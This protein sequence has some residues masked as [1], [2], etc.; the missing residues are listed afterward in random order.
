MCVFVCV[1]CEGRKRKRKRESERNGGGG[2]TAY[3]NLTWTCSPCRLPFS[4]HLLLLINTTGEEEERRQ[5]DGRNFSSP[6]LGFVLLS[7]SFVSLTEKEKHL[8]SL[9]LSRFL[10]PVYHYSLVHLCL[11]SISAEEEMLEQVLASLLSGSLAACGR[12]SRKYVAVGRWKKARRTATS[13]HATV[14]ICSK[15]F[16][17]V[18]G[19]RSLTQSPVTSGASPSNFANLYLLFVYSHTIFYDSSNFWNICALLAMSAQ[20]HLFQTLYTLANFT[21]GACV[22]VAGPAWLHCGF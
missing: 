22:S 11:P 12:P 16:P 21:F 13:Y 3:A 10:S 9:S 19:G 17:A 6:S 2:T 20:P 4:T 14:T 1:C 18:G 7:S 5:R 15:N 8:L